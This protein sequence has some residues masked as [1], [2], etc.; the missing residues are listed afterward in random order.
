[1]LVT[2]VM[3]D[4]FTSCGSTGCLAS[5]P[6]LSSQN[7]PSHEKSPA[8][9]RAQGETPTTSLAL[10]TNRE[11][12]E[13]V[14][15]KASRIQSNQIGS[16]LLVC[17]RRNAQ[18]HELK[19]PWSMRSVFIAVVMELCC[20]SK[21]TH[22]LP[23]KSSSALLSNQTVT[24]RITRKPLGPRENPNRESCAGRKS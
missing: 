10:G 1:M 8:T 23:N 18:H 21:W 2:V 6:P 4:V 12:K 22:R 7:V 24:Q 5:P 15:G 9:H 16:A 17:V 3:V 19:L 14:K 11:D 20:M 13:R